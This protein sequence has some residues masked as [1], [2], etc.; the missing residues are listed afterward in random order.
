MSDIISK[1]DKFQVVICNKCKNRITGIKCKA[2]DIIPDVVLFG[3]NDHSKPL[4]NQSNDVVFE[5]IK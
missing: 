4:P 2:F 3:E 1:N 5:S